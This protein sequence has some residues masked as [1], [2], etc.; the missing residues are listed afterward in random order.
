VNEKSVL[1]SRQSELLVAK[2]NLR[3]LER[4]VRAARRE[5]FPLTAGMVSEIKKGRGKRLR[6]K[7]RLQRKSGGVIQSL[8]R[9]ALVRVAYTDPLRDYWIECFDEDQGPEVYYYNTWSQETSWKVPNAVK[10]FHRKKEDMDFLAN[11]KAIKD[12]RGAE[13]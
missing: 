10:Y 3:A 6:A 8:W 12:G 5:L 1:K 11:I 13:Y 7:V 9:R 2:T 4:L